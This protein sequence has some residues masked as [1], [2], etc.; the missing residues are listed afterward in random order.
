MLK[1]N[2]RLNNM[3]EQV[4]SHAKYQ[5]ILFRRVLDKY[6]KK[7]DIYRKYPIFSI[8]SIFSI[9]FKK[10]MIFSI[11]GCMRHSVLVTCVSGVVVW[12]L[13]DAFDAW[14]TTS[15]GKP[16]RAVA[17]RPSEGVSVD[18]WRECGGGGVEQAA[19]SVKTEQELNACRWIHC[20][21]I[22]QSW[23]LLSS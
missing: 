17:Q 13:G 6:R 21:L 5:I 15:W 19:K 23:T 2:S 3:I 1:H 7:S 16:T 9:F 10:I 20:S 22:L 8:F 18:A 12:H 4:Y 14:L 11:P